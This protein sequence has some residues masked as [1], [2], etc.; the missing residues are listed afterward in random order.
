MN[1]SLNIALSISIAV[2][3]LTIASS[4]LWYKNNP[5][6]QNF[7]RKTREI[8]IF[9]QKMEKFIRTRD[10]APAKTVPQYVEENNLKK[11]II[12]NKNDFL[13]KPSRLEKN[14][15]EIILAHGVQD[16]NVESNPAYINYYKIIRGKIRDNAFRYYN[17][18]E[19][20]E[21]FLSFVVAG[22]GQLREI[23]LKKESTNDETLRNIAARS[24]KDASPFP[25]FPRELKEYHQLQFNISIHFKNN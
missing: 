17:Q 11:L 15:K 8:E 7:K 20:G 1:S 6:P 3:I 9:P 21:I 5:H 19:E 14:T 10:L 18:K 25:G 2:H 22:N 12:E 16:K 4:P 23:Y 24:V 13:G